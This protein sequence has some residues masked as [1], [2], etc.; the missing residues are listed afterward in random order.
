[1]RTIESAIGF[2]APGGICVPCAIANVER[3]IVIGPIHGTDHS[4]E[5]AVIQHFRPHAGNDIVEKFDEIPEK[6]WIDLPV[7]QRSSVNDDVPFGGCG[8]SGERGVCERP[9]NE[10]QNQWR[11]HAWISQR[12]LA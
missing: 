2:I 7:V 3:A 6:L 12:Y 8:S 4:F 9:E 10:C 11:F 1:P 5:G